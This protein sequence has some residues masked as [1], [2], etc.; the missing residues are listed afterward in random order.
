MKAFLSLT[1]KSYF[2]EAKDRVSLHNFSLL[3]FGIIEIEQPRWIGLLGDQLAQVCVLSMIALVVR[4]S[5][6]QQISPFHDPWVL[7]DIDNADIALYIQEALGES[8]PSPSRILLALLRPC[9]VIN[10]GDERLE[11]GLAEVVCSSTL[12]HPITEARDEADKVVGFH[13]GE[14][15]DAVL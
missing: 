3:H 2:G 10:P 1:P 8:L 12:R 13:L 14:S 7:V 11:P 4:L 5:L 9:K 6:A 15:V